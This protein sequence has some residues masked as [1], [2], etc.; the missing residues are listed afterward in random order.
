MLGMR[1]EYPKPRNDDENQHQ[2]DPPDTK[3]ERLLFSAACDK[4]VDSSDLLTLRFPSFVCGSAVLQALFGEDWLPSDI[5][6]FCCLPG[7]QFERLST[8]L[9][10]GSAFDHITRYREHYRKKSDVYVFPQMSDSE[11]GTCEIKPHTGIVVIDPSSCMLSDNIRVRGLMSTYQ[12]MRHQ[13]QHKYNA[14]CLSFYTTKP[15]DQ[16]NADYAQEIK[17]LTLLDI[18]MTEYQYSDVFE[19][20]KSKFDYT[21][22]MVG[23]RPGCLRIADLWNTA[24]KCGLYNHDGLHSDLTRQARYEERGFSVFDSDRDMEEAI[25]NGHRAKRMRL[26]ETP[27]AF[28]YFCGKQPSATTATTMSKPRRRTA[29]TKTRLVLPKRSKTSAATIRRRPKKPKTTR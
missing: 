2:L 10:Y 9:A 15:R 22:C 14:S 11:L 17:K 5:D 20:I 13:H 1:S 12:V 24:A 28:G 19:Q 18:V 7:H 23:A 26:S 3:F 25:S 21:F 27:S 16:S 4:T 6:I 8:S 29:F